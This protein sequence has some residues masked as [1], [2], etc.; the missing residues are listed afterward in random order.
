MLPA[1]FSAIFLAASFSWSDATSPV[2]SR[3]LPCTLTK[4]VSLCKLGS[5]FSARWI[6]LCA[7]WGLVAPWGCAPVC[8]PAG[9][10]VCPCAPS[11]FGGLT[12]PDGWF[13]GVVGLV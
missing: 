7:S 3:S 4:M 2:R 1:Y 11:G 9:G 13:V 12:W 5:L 6:W 8:A 10:V